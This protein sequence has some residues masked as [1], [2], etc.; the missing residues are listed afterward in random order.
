MRYLLLIFV[1]FSQLGFAKEAELKN[2]SSG[3][4]ASEMMRLSLSLI[5]VL[6]IIVVF[7]WAIKKLNH[8]SSKSNHHIKLITGMN[9]GL[10]EKIIVL[11]VANQQMVIGVTPHSIN[12]LTKIDEKI[13]EDS[14]P[15]A[16]FNEVFKKIKNRDFNEKNSQ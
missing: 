11:E 2:F 10:K 9:I 1:F 8:F 5:L 16:G 3:I 15:M 12:Y 7:S 13:E 14:K 6:A 4:N